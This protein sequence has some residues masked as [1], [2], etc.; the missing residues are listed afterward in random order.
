MDL[1]RPEEVARELRISLFTVRKK[2][3]KKEIPTVRIGGKIFT[4][5]GDLEEWVKN[6]RQ[7]GIRNERK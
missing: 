4:L 7:E 5:R 3:W 2:I 6:Q 1:L